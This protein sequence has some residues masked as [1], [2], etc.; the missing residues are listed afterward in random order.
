[1]YTV[2]FQQQALFRRKQNTIIGIFDK[3]GVSQESWQGIR[4]T[5][6]DYYRKLFWS[7]RPKSNHIEAV[8]EWLELRRTITKEMNDQPYRPFCREEIV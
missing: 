8:K 2:W 3:D 7:S 6:V 4:N 5:F 1:M